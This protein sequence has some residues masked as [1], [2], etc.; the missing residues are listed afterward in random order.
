MGEEIEGLGRL[1]DW[2]TLEGGDGRTG[3][4]LQALLQEVDWGMNR[5]VG[6]EAVV[7]ANGHRA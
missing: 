5:C 7:I 3:E 4:A 2:E 6:E 1:R